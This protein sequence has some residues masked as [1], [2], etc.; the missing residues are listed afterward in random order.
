MQDEVVLAD[1]RPTPYSPDQGHQEQVQDRF[2]I[3]TTG[4]ADHHGP[5]I[6]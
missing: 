5:P 2:R 6:N 4:I 1:G 3:F